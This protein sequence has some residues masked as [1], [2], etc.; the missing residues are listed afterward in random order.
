MF[1]G[2]NPIGI[3]SSHQVRQNMFVCKFFLK[4][5][6]A[7]KL[8]LPI[9]LYLYGIAGIIFHCVLTLRFVEKNSRIHR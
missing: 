6:R 4:N 2:H 5:R 8:K 7:V 1:H 3:G 9:L